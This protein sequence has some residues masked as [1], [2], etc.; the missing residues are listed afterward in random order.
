MIGDKAKIRYVLLLRGINVGGVNKVVMADLKTHLTQMGFENP[1]SYINSG[2][3]FFDS[4]EP[5]KKIKELLINYFNNT[6][7]FPLPFALI[8]SDILQKEADKLP[9]WWQDETAYRRDVLFYL[10]EADREQIKAETLTWIDEKEHL[11]FGETA[12]FY[13]N[14]NQADYLL[15]NYHKKLVGSAFYKSLTIR[16]GKTFQKII[17]LANKK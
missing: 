9:D 2:N 3:L 1:V 4:K 14:H 11:H 8:R 16:N 7:D 6:Y 15:S 12:F 5:E 13:S 10:P 17:E